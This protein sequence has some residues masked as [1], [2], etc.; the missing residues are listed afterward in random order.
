M[1][2]G[3]MYAPN[4]DLEATAPVEAEIHADANVDG[5]S[6]YAMILTHNGGAVGPS[7]SS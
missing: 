5:R 2:Q 7:T 4:V 1:L 3:G 6:V